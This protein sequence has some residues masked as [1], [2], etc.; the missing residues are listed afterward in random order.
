MRRSRSTLDKQARLLVGDSAFVCQIVDL[1]LS[2]VR[3]E[4]VSGLQLSVGQPVIFEVP[5]AGSAG[6]SVEA[7]V[8]RISDDVLALRFEHLNRSAENG[9][10]AVLARQG[11]LLG[12]LE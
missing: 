6:A 9:L 12:A 2:G 7:R 10:E 3:L 1:S 8:S 4:P 11:R 5:T